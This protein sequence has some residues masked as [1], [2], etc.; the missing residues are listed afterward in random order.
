MAR[1]GAG[2]ELDLHRVSRMPLSSRRAAGACDVELVKKRRGRDTGMTR[3]ERSPEQPP[4]NAVVPLSA[5]W[6]TSLRPRRIS[7]SIAVSVLA[8]AVKTWRVPWDVSTLPKRTS[9]WR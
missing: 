3:M 4:L 9:R 7:A 6:T 1:S 2:I 5:F 8:T